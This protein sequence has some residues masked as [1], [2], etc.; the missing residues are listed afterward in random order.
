MHDSSHFITSLVVA[1][2][3]AES[4][5]SLCMWF[6][7]SLLQKRHK[8]IEGGV[9]PRGEKGLYLGGGPSCQ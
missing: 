7:F 9:K 4:S 1:T 5:L 6:T 8:E 3:N 2:K